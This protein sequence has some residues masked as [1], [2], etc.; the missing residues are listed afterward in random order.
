MRTAIP[1]PKRIASGGNLTAVLG[2]T[3]A[4]MK[5]ASAVAVAAPR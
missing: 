2:P 5:P 4:M 1:R 3:M